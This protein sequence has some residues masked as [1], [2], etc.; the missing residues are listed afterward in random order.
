MLT[1]E[2]CDTREDASNK[3]FVVFGFGVGVLLLLLPLLHGSCVSQHGRHL[4]GGELSPQNTEQ[5]G[6][7]WGRGGIDSSCSLVFLLHFF[8]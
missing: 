1:R 7:M 8:F 4:G 2:L 3:A 6:Y 5:S